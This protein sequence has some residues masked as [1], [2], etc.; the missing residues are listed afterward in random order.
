[1]TD[2]TPPCR[3]RLYRVFFLAVS[4]IKIAIAAPRKRISVVVKMAVEFTR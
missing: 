4:P 3:T 1:M 2:G